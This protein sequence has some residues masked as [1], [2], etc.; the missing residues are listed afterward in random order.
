MSANQQ[1]SNVALSFNGRTRRFER[2]NVGSRLTGASNL[3]TPLGT[4][5]K[6]FADTFSAET[7]IMSTYFA[8]PPAPAR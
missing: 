2:R 1:Q 7:V 8:N 4:P 6:A 3:D 5:V